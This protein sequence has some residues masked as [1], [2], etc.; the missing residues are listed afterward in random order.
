M[1]V[2]YV[3]VIYVVDMSRS[4]RARTA[5][6]CIPI[7]EAAN[8]TREY[9]SGPLGLAVAKNPAIANSK[10]AKNSIN[11]ALVIALGHIFS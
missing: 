3:P 2:V 1:K 6:L 11:K 10:S 9:E 4:H 5:T 7:D 8:A